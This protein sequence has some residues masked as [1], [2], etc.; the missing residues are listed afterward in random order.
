LHLPNEILAIILH[1]LASDNDDTLAALAS[2]RLASHVLCSLAT[3]FLFSSIRLTDA[4]TTGNKGQ[5]CSVL[6]ERAM[7]LNKILTIYNIASSVHTLT[8]CCG[9]RTLENSISATLMSTILL[10]LPRIH[11]FALKS[12]SYFSSIPEDFASAIQAL[13]QSPNLTSLNLDSIKGFPFE[14]I[15]SN[16]RRLRLRRVDNFWVKFSVVSVLFPQTHFLYFILYSS[17][18]K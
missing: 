17:S 13:C 8:L 11:T 18:T 14:I 5:D 1:E 12:D 3:H 10:R 4:F 7:K 6:V 2:C 9:Q 15:T 16:L